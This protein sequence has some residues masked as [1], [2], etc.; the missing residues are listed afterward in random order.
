MQQS[1][2]QIKAMYGDNNAS[3]I[4]NNCDHILYLGGANDIETAEFIAEHINKTRNTVLSLENNKA[5]LITRGK[6]CE[7]VDKV[8]PFHSET[9]LYESEPNNLD[10]FTV[11]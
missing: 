7:Y 4:L 8:K 6:L 10:S 3:T 2:S 9:G 11:E 5:I 1:I